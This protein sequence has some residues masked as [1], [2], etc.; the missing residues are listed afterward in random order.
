M[1]TIIH[2]TTVVTADDACTVQYDA[3]LVVDAD[4]IGVT[5][6]IHLYG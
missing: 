5:A 1:P 4:R 6:T 2:D 3:A